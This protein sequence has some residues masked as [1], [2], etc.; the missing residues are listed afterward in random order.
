MDDQATIATHPRLL[1]SVRNAREAR[2]AFSG[3]CDIL[4][5]K[6]PS[7]GS[8]GMADVETIAD[9]VDTVKSTVAMSGIVMSA[10][11]GEA[12]DWLRGDPPPAL[13][14]GLDY[15]KLGLAGLGDRSD[16]IV[17]WQQVRHQ[18]ESQAMHSVNWIAVAYVDW[19][20]AGSPRPGSVL[21]AAIATGCAGML[22]D[23]QAKLDR[24]LLD[25]ISRDELSHLAK[26][27]HGNGL[28]LAV[29]GRLHTAVL[30]AVITA[31][32]DIVAIRTAGCRAGRRSGE[33]DADAVRN[34]KTAL[35][36][37]VSETGA[38]RST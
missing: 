35:T 19:Q 28:Q 4:D 32:P 20:P 15:V 12:V 13:P 18:F 23:T 31:R 21:E 9:V 6:E 3:G 34:F 8:L 27:A 10:A 26:Q 2:A 37:A 7:R 36:N 17:E 5:V 14:A 24:T 1:V 29:A 38:A 16:W 22:L 33:I 25:W 11:L 30:P